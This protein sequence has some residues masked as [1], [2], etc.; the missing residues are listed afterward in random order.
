MLDSG[1]FRMS[2]GNAMKLTL[3]FAIPLFRGRREP[4][5]ELPACNPD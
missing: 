2:I 4:K 1:D 3:F 5:G